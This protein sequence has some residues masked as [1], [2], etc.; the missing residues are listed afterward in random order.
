MRKGLE[1]G[2]KN[3]DGKIEVAKSALLTALFKIPKGAEGH[4]YE[5]ERRFKP[6]RLLSEEELLLKSK[7]QF[8]DIEQAYIFVSTA[9]GK[10]KTVRLRRTSPEAEGQLLRIAHKAK[11]AQNPTGRD[12]YQ[13]KFPETDA[14]EDEFEKLWKQHTW[15]TLTKRR[16]YIDHTIKDCIFPD[17][18]KKDIQCEIHYDIHSGGQLH[19]FVRIEVEFKNDEDEAYVRDWKGEESLLPDWVGEDVTGDK[20]YVSKALCRDGK[21][22]EGPKS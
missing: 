14:R 11:T 13:I 3:P 6:A 5:V 19:G 4:E 10:E 9:N 15:K 22:E 20:R 18:K 8:R 2:G 17:G 16:F 21:P 12:E 7:G 1:R